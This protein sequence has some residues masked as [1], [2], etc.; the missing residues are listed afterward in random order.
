DGGAGRQ[1]TRRDGGPR[2]PASRRDGGPQGRDSPKRRRRHASDVYGH[3]G[4]DGRAVRLRLLLRDALALISAL[5]AARSRRA[6]ANTRRP[7]GGAA[8]TL[9]PVRTTCAIR[10]TAVADTAI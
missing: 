10:R 1:A 5:L 6:R 7:W 4:T 8:A 3:P 2:R 9:Q